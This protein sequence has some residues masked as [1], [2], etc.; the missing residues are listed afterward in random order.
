MFMT[1]VRPMDVV[2]AFCLSV[3]VLRAALP[4]L[5]Q[6]ITQ[7][8]PHVSSVMAGPPANVYPARWD[9]SLRVPIQ[10]ML[11][12][13]ASTLTSALNTSLGVWIPPLTETASRSMRRGSLAAGSTK[14]LLAPG[15]SL[16]VS[17]SWSGPVTVTAG[18]LVMLV[19]A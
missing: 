18:E 16:I 1:Y 4:E 14:V 5:S 3:T 13:L 17:R 15:A 19:T 10:L 7:L 9:P 2:F 11:A 12:P 8:E 6:A